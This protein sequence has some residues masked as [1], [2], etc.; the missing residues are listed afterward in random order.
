MLGSESAIDGAS[1]E[2]SGGRMPLVES[3]GSKEAILQT[4]IPVTV[5]LVVKVESVKREATRC[6]CGATGPLSISGKINPR[7][8]TLQPSSFWT[9][10]PLIYYY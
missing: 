2:A 10:M 7:V 5:V 4:V 6:C 8:L 1:A 3:D 9:I